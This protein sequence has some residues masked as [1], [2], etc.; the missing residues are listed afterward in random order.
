M[1]RGAVFASSVAAVQGAHYAVLVAGSNSYSNYRHQADVCHAYQVVKGAGIPE[2]NIIVMAYDDIANNSKNPFPGKI[3]N[4]PTAAGV[5]GVDVYAGCRIDYSGKDVTPATFQ[6]VL[7]GTASGKKLTSTTNDNVFIFFSD[8]GA[9]GLIA[10]P[11]GQGQLHKADL[12]STFDTMHSKGMYKKLVMYLE[13]CESGSM[14]QGMTTPGVYALS[15]S[16]PTESSWGYYCS[17]STGGSSVNGK[18]IGSCLGDLFSIAW[19]EDSDAVDIT[20][21]T[22]DAQFNTVYT[23]TTKSEVMQWGDLTFKTDKVSDFQGTTGTA[24]NGIRAEPVKDA[25]ATRQIDLRMAYQN[26]VDATTTEERLARGEELQAVLK[27]QLEVEATYERFLEIVYPNDSAKQ[28]AAR[29]MNHPADQKDCELAAR[30]SFIDHGNFDSWT[31]FAL[32]F[33]K[34]IVNT[35]ADV[36]ASGANIDLAQAAK[37]ACLGTAVV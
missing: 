5:A 13:T 34:Y 24:A 16:N 27:D 29:E 7:T 30:Q 15:A 19:M 21:E 8:H 4:K 25:W 14:F 32:G 23:R 11:T 20:S 3:F 33:H 36:A 2:E 22:L 37:Q 17:S 28:Q 1:M 26:Y 12:Q 10:F 31:G 18:S 35:C 6:A 9:P